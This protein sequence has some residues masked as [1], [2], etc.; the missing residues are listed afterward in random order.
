MIRSMVTMLAVLAASACSSSKGTGTT[1][2]GVQRTPD[3]DAHCQEA[4]R[5]H[6]YEYPDQDAAEA[7]GCS[8]TRVYRSVKHPKTGQMMD[9]E[10]WIFCCPK[11]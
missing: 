9:D 8:V 4:A 1:A 3:N 10:Q 2:A 7:A 11:R 6:A 5:P